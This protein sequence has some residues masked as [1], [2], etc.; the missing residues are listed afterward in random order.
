MRRAHIVS[1]GLEGAKELWVF[2]FSTIGGA[3]ELPR[4]SQPHIIDMYSCDFLCE[5]QGVSCKT[6]MFFQGVQPDGALVI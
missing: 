2:I 6:V 5:F 1:S 4:L 3:K